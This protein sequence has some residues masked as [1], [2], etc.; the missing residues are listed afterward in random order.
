MIQLNMIHRSVLPTVAAGILVLTSLVVAQD[1]KAQPSPP[2]TAAGGRGLG[3]RDIHR[4]RELHH[5]TDV[6]GDKLWPGYDTR[7]IPIAVNNDDRQEILIGHPAPPREFRDFK[8]HDIDGKP[9]M[10]RDGV[11]RYGPRS[12]GWAVQLGGEHT[13]YVSVLQKGQS[14]ESYLSLLLHECFHVY[15]R[16]YRQRAEGNVAS[17]PTDDPVYAAMIGLESRILH[18]ALLED[19]E[20]KL[21]ELCRMFVAVRHARR[22]PLAAGV[23]RKE[24]EQ[25]YNEGTATYIQ[26]RLFQLMAQSG[27]IKPAVASGDARYKG[28]ASAASQYRMYKARVLP[29]TSRP[30][31]F[32]HS[33]YQCGMA[34][35]LLLDRVRPKWK[36]EMRENGRTQFDLLERQFPVT[37]EEHGALVADAKK[38][39]AYEGL[40]AGQKKLVGDR[41]AKIKSLLEA[42]GRR[43]RVY[44]SAIPG[45][46]KWK[47]RGPVY[48]VPPALLGD[49]AEAIVIEGSRGRSTILNPRV[50]IWGGGMRF[51]KGSLLLE[52]GKVPVVFRPDYLEWTDTDPDPKGKDLKIESRQV[53]GGVHHELKITTD[54]FTLSIDRARVERSASVVSIRPVERD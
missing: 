36:E 17:L 42:K 45:R 41:V 48:R 31:T 29:A 32:F 15:Q 12:G 23:V 10:I 44:H 4:I 2:P 5:L 14:T 3:N 47:P 27:G 20:E 28:F 30:I 43:Y 25:E 39:F 53:V 1:R 7:K 8:G 50:T 52:S 18:A 51:E 49:E 37:D 33:Q 13:A 21:H 11:T 16:R 35:C 40:L 38:R 22:K 9:V 46:F 34:Q 6:L 19:R 54:G 24:G 26:A